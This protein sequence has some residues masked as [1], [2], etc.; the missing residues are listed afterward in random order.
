MQDERKNTSIRISADGERLRA[1]LAKLLGISKTAVI[2]IALREL[3]AKHGV[4]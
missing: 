2:E 4:K 1:A 3:A